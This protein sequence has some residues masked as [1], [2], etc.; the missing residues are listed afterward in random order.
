LHQAM[1][2][3]RVNEHGVFP[4]IKAGNQEELTMLCNEFGV[5]NHSKSEDEWVRASKNGDAV[6][7]RKN[8]AGQ[9]IVPD[10]SGMTF[11]DAIFLLEKSGLK[12]FYVGKGRVAEQSLSPGTR[13]S[14]GSRIFIKLS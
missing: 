12:V 9:N 6:D 3:R 1:D 5:A 8:I 14:K 7:W 2:K 11:R 10:V 4:V 13:I